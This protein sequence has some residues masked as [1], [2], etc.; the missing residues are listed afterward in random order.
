MRW[1]VCFG[2]I[3]LSYLLRQRALGSAVYG[4]TRG[5]TASALLLAV[6]A[7]LQEQQQVTIGLL[8]L[9]VVFGY[10]AYRFGTLYGRELYLQFLVTTDTKP[11]APKPQAAEGS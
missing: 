1:T 9:A 7:C 2:S 11:P 8:V 6:T 10:R 3:I 5:L 4:L